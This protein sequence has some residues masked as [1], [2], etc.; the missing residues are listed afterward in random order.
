MKKVFVLLIALFLIS[1]CATKEM[2]E[3]EVVCEP[4]RIMSNGGCCLDADNSGV[5]DKD[6]VAEE[7]TEEITEEET[8]ESEEL[9]TPD[10]CVEMSSWVT[11][12]DVDITYDEVIERGTI[13]LQLK[14]NREGIL[15]I[16]NFKFPTM[17]SCNKELSWSRDTTGMQI[18]EST[19]YIIEC[20]I[21]SKVNVLDVEIEMDANYYEKV[22]G[23][24]TEQYMSEVEQTIKGKILGSP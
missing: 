7:R 10:Q 12:E 3:P 8:A 23:T 19:K 9:K 1:G 4:P 14:N 24:T 15:V 16:K 18:A 13:E 11:C 5:C 6:E 21:L 22:Q 2:I 17:P 20:D